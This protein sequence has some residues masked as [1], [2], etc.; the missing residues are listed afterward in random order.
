MDRYGPA[1]DKIGL[2]FP[3]QHGTVQLCRRS[4]A[5]SI[6]ISGVSEN[7]W[8]ELSL[9]PRSRA[10]RGCYPDL[11]GPHRFERIG[12]LFFLPAQ[13]RMHARSECRDQA[14][15]ICTF[16]PE[17]LQRWFG[18]AMEWTD[19]RLQ[20]CLDIYNKTIRSLMFRIGEEIRQP[21]F[22]S[23]MLIE[24]MSAQLAIEI[25]RHC[26][27]I[28]ETRSTGGLAPWR[29][30]LIDDRLTEISAPPSLS[31]LAAH[32]GL[33]VRQLSRAFRVSRGCSLGDYIAGCQID[34]AKQLLMAGQPIHAIASLTGFQSPTNF[35]TAFRKATG[36]TPRQYRERIEP[37]G[38]AMIAP[39]LSLH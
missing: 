17:A 7:H 26:L 36:E 20:G 4:W 5:A 12:E 14:S 16:R 35:S 15:I 13:Y 21:Y 23:E 18:G 30:R 1:T 39:S 38:I 32:C 31:E 34:H 2:C 27:G 33:S 10:A 24:L 29:L 9:L 6:D 3:T 28:E 8:L 37:S 25:G 11:W 19:A 22:A